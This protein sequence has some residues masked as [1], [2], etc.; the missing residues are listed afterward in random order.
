MKAVLFE[1]ARFYTGLREDEY[2][3]YMLVEKGR[4]KALSNQRPGDRL[5]GRSV[6]LGGGNVY[7]CMA[8]PHVHLLYTIVLSAMGFD[9]CTIE[10]GEV[11]P[12]TIK[13]IEEKLRSFAAGKKPGEMVVANNYILSGIDELRLPTKDE[14]DDWCGGR[15][16]VVYT[17]D[18]HASALSSAMLRKIGIEPEGHSGVLMGEEHERV[19]GRITDAISSMVTPKVL[20]RGIAN[21]ENNC[22]AMGISHLGA[23]EGNGDSEKDITTRL[24]VFLARRMKINVRLYLQ[25]FDIDRV[26][27]FRKYLKKP[28]L[29]GCG[30][31]EMDGATGAHS[32]AFYSPFKDTGR[33]APCY[34]E[35][36]KVN[37]NVEKAAALGYQ[38]ASHAIGECAIERITEALLRIKPGGVFH[39]VEHGE[40]FNEECFE[41]YKSGRFAVVM[42]PGYA[43]I[44]KHFLRSYEKFLPEEIVGRLKFGSLYKA[45]VCVCGSSDSPVQSIDPYIQMTGMTDFYHREESVSVYEAF[46]CCSINAARALGEEVEMGTLEVGKRADFFVADR[47]LFEIAPHELSSFRPRECWYQGKKW[48]NKKGSIGELIALL[49]TLPHKI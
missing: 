8:D 3:K 47:H 46:R 44:D 28:R 5:F 14:L 48:Q 13:G 45:G 38:I 15:A 27:K 29:G 1:N 9:V 26:E 2:Y 18:G 6:D 24:L 16:T 39:R 4:I 7:P 11:T 35:Q 33:T 49:L 40:F 30:Q 41:R 36:D 21:V 34:Y 42:Q 20:A 32:S 10:N 43:W 12:N 31:W 37:E 22:A 25:Y 19:Q 17:I 23:L